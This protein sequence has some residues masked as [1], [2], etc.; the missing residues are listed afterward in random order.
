LKR[1]EQPLVESVQRPTSNTN[2]M[3]LYTQALTKMNKKD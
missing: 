1:E 3:A 2:E